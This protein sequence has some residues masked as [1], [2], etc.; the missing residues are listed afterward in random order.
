LGANGVGLPFWLLF[1]LLFGLAIAL[2]YALAG[3]PTAAAGPRDIIR[4]DLLSELPP[5]LAMGL[6]FGLWVGLLGGPMVVGVIAG[7]V[8]GGAAYKVTT[9]RRTFRTTLRPAVR[10]ERQVNSSAAPGRRYLAFLVSSRGRLPWRLGAFLD[11]ACA[12][13]MMRLAG[14]AYQ[15]RHREL[16]QWLTH[17]PSPPTE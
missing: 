6:W 12:A 17:H 7:V 15:F 16:Q 13:G 11:W 4:G 8:T 9:P 2:P 1:G 14:T 5:R 3:E 10:G